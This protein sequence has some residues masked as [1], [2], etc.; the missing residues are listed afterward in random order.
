MSSF[1]EKK[2][3]DVVEIEKHRKDPSLRSMGTIDIP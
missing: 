2:V 3:I 1:M